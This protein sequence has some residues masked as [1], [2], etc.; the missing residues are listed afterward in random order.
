[1]KCL[2]EGYKALINGGGGEEEKV[3]ENEMV[4][5]M[6]AHSAEQSQLKAISG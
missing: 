2:T 5:E 1:V 4:F 3:K 6:T